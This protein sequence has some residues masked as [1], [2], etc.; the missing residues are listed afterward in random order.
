MTANIFQVLGWPTLGAAI[1]VF[2]FAPGVVLRLILLLYRKDHPRRRELLGELYAVPMIE[3]PFWVAQQLEV[4]FFEGLPSRFAT[5]RRMSARA[6]AYTLA[7][8]RV[9]PL[10]ML[11]ALPLNFVAQAFGLGLLSTW[12]MTF[13]LMLASAGVMVAWDV[14]RAYTRRRLLVGMFAVGCLALTALRVEF[15]VAVAAESIVASVLQ[16]SLLTAIV[17]GLVVCGAVVLARTQRG[18]PRKDERP[19]G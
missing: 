7:V 17:A 15:L 6:R 11:T 4:A 19:R 1:L 12:L 9:G 2:G 13:I 5:R 8:A 18:H 16:A 14:T 10:V 3:R